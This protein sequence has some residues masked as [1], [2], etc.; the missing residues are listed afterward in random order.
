ME[1]T[2]EFSSRQMYAIEAYV[3]DKGFICLKQGDPFEEQVVLL[4]R[5]QVPVVIGWLRD[6][7]AMTPDAKE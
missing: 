3:S 6:L 2:P 7:L 5:D 4:T 1:D